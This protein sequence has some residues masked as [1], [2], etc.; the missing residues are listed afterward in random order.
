MTSEICEKETILEGYFKDCKKGKMGV[1]PY[2]EGQRT[3]IFVWHN[4]KG[5]GREAK[6]SLTKEG[7][8]EALKLYKEIEK[9]NKK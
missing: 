4:N 8:E 2:M 3:I 9:L 5:Y 6:L 1:M 7:M